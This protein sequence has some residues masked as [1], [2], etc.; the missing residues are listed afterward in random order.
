MYF[1]SE[2]SLP[3]SSLTWPSISEERFHVLNISENITS[4]GDYFK[5]VI[6][7]WKEIGICCPNGN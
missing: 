7:F 5:K 1:S 4:D 2:P 3:D 6:D